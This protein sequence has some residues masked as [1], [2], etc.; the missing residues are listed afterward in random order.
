M[1]N[2]S[3]TTTKEQEI[4]VCEKLRQATRTYSI[5]EYCKGTH[6]IYCTIKV[7]SKGGK[8]FKIYKSLNN[9]EEVVFYITDDL[10]RKSKRSVINYLTKN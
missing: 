9:L 1:E 10:F 6:L 5:S 2:T 4:K 8:L 7:K 3:N